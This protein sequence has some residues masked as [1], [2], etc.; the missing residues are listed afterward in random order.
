MSKFTTPSGKN[1]D[2]YI[3]PTT[4]H[5]RIK[6]L[7]GGI[8]PDEL[9]GVFTSVALADI[10]IQTYLLKNAVEHNKRVEKKE[11]AEAKVAKEYSLKEE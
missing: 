1:I 4:A 3:C 9:S 11:K 7:E 2:T 10:A 5:V 8:L 6:L